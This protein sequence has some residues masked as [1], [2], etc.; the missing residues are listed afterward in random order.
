MVFRH[1]PANGQCLAFLMLEGEGGVHG[2]QWRPYSSND[3]A[4]AAA[5]SGPELHPTAPAGKLNAGPGTS[6][7]LWVSR[8]GAMRVDHI[9][10]ET[11]D[12]LGSLPFPAPRSHGMFWDDGD[13]SLSVAET[14]QGNVY[15]FDPRLGEVL[16]QWRIEG[17]E[18]HGLTRSQDGR[19]WIGDA[20]SNHVLVVNA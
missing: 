4:P 12:L 13:G 20:A 19:V 10:A 16:D 1:D 11:G 3:A 9:D 5:A 2:L 6:G 8:P 18:V 15:R 14:N 7:T 17:A